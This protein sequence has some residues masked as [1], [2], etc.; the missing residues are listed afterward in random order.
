M[1]PII[2]AFE[3]KINEK[4][5]EIS[6]HL[7]EKWTVSITYFLPDKM[8]SGGAYLTDIGTVKKIDEIEKVIVMDNGIKISMEQIIEIVMDVL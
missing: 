6:Q 4:L 7:S 3:E 1:N 8:K 5:Y 2:E